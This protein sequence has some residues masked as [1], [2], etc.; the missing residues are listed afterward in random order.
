VLQQYAQAATEPLKK[1]KAQEEIASLARREKGFGTGRFKVEPAAKLAGEAFKRGRA[2]FKAKKYDL[3]AMYFKAGIEMAPDLVGNYRELGESLDK[4]G[5]T[6]EANQFFV[7]YLQRRPFGKNADLVRV[8]LA[9][10]KLVGKLTIDSALPCDEVWINGQPLAASTKLP[11]KNH[12]VAPGSYKLLCFSAK[13]HHAQFER[14]EVK[15]GANVAV[16]FAWAVLENR[17]EPWGR[18]VIENPKD[19]TQMMDIGLWEEVGVPVPEDRRALKIVMTAGDGSKRKEEFVK[20][21]PG[22]RIVLKW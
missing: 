8:R 15:Q 1:Q 17:L 6:D 4:L 21:A 9:K 19:K 3:A 14:V 18:V 13:Y 11:I 5:R 20:L 16:S 10:A 2:A 12:V 7:R 22:Q